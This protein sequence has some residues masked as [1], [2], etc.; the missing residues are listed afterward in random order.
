VPVCELD[1]SGNVV[2]QTM[3]GAQGLVSRNTPASGTVWYAFDERGNVAQRVGGNGAVLSTDLY[4]GF[5]K[6]RSGAADVFGFGGQ[7][8]YYTD[9]ETGLVLC[10]NRHYD[11]QSGRFLTRDPLGYG[12]GIN[13]YSYTQ[14]NPVNWMDPSGHGV[15]TTLAGPVGRAWTYGKAVVALGQ[16]TSGSV[17]AV[18]DNGQ[19][20]VAAELREVVEAHG[21]EAAP[22]SAEEGI[23]AQEVGE[24]FA[25]QGFDSGVVE[26]SSAEILG[27]GGE[28][29]GAAE[30]LGGV[31]AAGGAGG[32]A[33]AV[34][35]VVVIAAGV[36]AVAD[37]AHYAAT[38]KS[39]GFFTSLGQKIADKLFPGPDG[40]PAPD[41]PRRKKCR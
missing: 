24:G 27:A 16:A 17:S 21:T 14:N 2:A 11:P 31:A 22:G 4:D 13:L 35:P 37:L 10:T 40:L 9:V 32:A 28:G 12:G 3:F 5:G 23:N 8:G 30:G 20:S 29:L 26:T 18:A 15:M 6:R 25:K 39:N 41:Q 38:G 19:T 1:A 34:L 33:V 7:A 36:Y